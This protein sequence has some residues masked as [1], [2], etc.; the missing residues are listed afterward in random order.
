MSQSSK[1]PQSKGSFGKS[2]KRILTEMKSLKNLIYLAII[3]AT[4]SSILSIYSPTKLAEMTDEISAGIQID[5]NKMEDLAT[6][7]SDNLQSGTPSELEYENQKI[8]LE[9]QL[10][11]VDKLKVLNEINASRNEISDEKQKE[12][13][14][15]FE[16]IPQSVKDIIEPKINL[17]KIWSI[18]QFLIMLYLLSGVFNYLQSFIIS[19]ATNNFAKEL[20]TKVSHKINKLPLNY[21][22]TN[23][24]GDILS[25]V[26]NDVDSIA[27][28]LNQS[29]GTL[30][31]SATLLI[32][33]VVM[34][35]YTNWTLALVAIV[36]SL[37]GFIFMFLVLGN[38]QK[39]FKKRQEQLGKINGNIEENFSGL[40]IVKV[41]NASENSTNEFNKLNKEMFGA[42]IMSKFLSSLMQ[43][44][45]LFVGNLG[46]LAVSVAGSVL[47]KNEL[48]TFGIIIA[49]MTYV[50][51]FSNPLAQIAQAMQS[52]QSSTAASER[53]FEFL[54]E[55]ELSNENNLTAKINPNTAK[56]K[57]EFKDVVF[58][59]PSN[60]NP[61]ITGFSA[62][63]N[64][65]KKIAIVGPTGA[66]KST[67]VNLLMKFY[68]ITSGDILID[69]V[70]IHDIKRENIH[71]LFTMVLQDT[72]LFNGTIRDN[73]KYNMESITD[74]EL[75]TLS[76]FVGLTHL[77][78]T[79]PNGYDTEISDAE[80]VSSGQKQLLTI[81]RGMLK[82]APFLILDE[83]TSNVDTRTEEV[84]QEA[85][86]KLMYG[87]TAFIIA[88]RLSTIINSDLIIV[89]NEGN[90][91]ELGN[92]EELMQKNGFYADLYNSQFSL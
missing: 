82:Q 71:D 54:D 34:M 8:S 73:I 6:K 59:Y 40:N 28:N 45:M 90:I 53:V 86:D 66:G 62:I 79:L 7:I 78:N 74:E 19:E 13:I 46:Y 56:G 32:G 21:F 55:K 84:V 17:E 2:I 23:Q 89:M 70:S 27:M 22:D 30:V 15:T 60:I 26:T 88:H 20:R 42:D 57:I 25:R 52:L 18:G 64:P 75:D 47:V 38:S 77:I 41:Y 9:D 69:G 83:A 65:G 81:A 87:K 63:A 92:H 91:V 72:W 50:R 3:L 48:I 16:A 51:Q 11:F 80:S 49:F 67:M 29:L 44:I 24:I 5:N 37:I 85:M 43:P 10:S 35:F 33:A 31:S 76:N 68:E 39:Y 12:L 61:T 58:Q 4:I 1:N 14:N 36:S